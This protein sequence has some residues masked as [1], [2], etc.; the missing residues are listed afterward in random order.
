MRFLDLKNLNLHLQSQWVCED[1]ACLNKLDDKTR[2]FYENCEE[3]DL[4]TALII[5]YNVITSK[6][7]AN[8]NEEKKGI[9]ETYTKEHSAE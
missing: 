5:G 6:H 3:N 2:E 8:I 4:I 9:L 7:Y 1:L